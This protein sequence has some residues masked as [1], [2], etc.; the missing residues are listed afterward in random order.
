MSATRFRFEDLRVY[1]SALVFVSFVYSIIKKWPQLYKFGLADQFQRAA[2]SIPLN[3]AEGSG[4]TAKDFQHF[5]SVARGSCYECIAI[6]A[7]AKNEKLLSQSEYIKLYE[8]IAV[9]AKTLSSLKSSISS[10]K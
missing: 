1:Q 6:L 4:R 10:S 3:I 2:L 8:D 7:V 5:L 9:L